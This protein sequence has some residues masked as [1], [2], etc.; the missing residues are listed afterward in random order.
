M[1][2]NYVQITGISLAPTLSLTPNVTLQGKLSYLS[3][4]YLGNPGFV[5]VVNSRSDTEHIVQVAV[6]W[7]PIRRTTVTLALEK[8]E[9]ASN[10][11]IFSYD[12]KTIGV[13][14]VYNF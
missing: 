3:D 4:K 1:N 7:T 10:L 12:Y 14:A 5:P 2:S 6:L 11:A 8:G 9:R 13:T